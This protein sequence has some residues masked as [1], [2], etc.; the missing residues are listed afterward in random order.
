MVTNKRYKGNKYENCQMCDEV[1]ADSL[2]GGKFT[3][4]WLKSRSEGDT[5][6][7][8]PSRIMHITFSSISQCLETNQNYLLQHFSLSFKI[9]KSNLCIT[10]DDYFILNYIIPFYFSLLERKLSNLKLNN[11]TIR[12]ITVLTYRINRMIYLLSVR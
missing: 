8:N 12:L 11:Q 9:N 6:I 10:W 3:M 5:I 2:L 7:V 4:T 1:C